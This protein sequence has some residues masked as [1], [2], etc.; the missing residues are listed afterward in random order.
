MEL[1]VVLRAHLV[2][3]DDNVSLF[4]PPLSIGLGMLLVL[5]EGAYLRTQDWQYE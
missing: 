5:M 3:A 2:R 1:R 4:S